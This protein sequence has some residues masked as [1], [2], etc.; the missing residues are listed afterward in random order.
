MEI[1]ADADELT[2]LSEEG[3]FYRY[4]FDK[5]ISHKSGI[6]LDRYGWPEETQ[7]YLDPRT[8]TNRAWAMGKRNLHVLYYEDPF[9]NQHHNGTMEI[10][11]TYVL[12]EDGQEICYGDTGLPSDF[13]RN[14]LGPER[15]AFKA[16][17]LSASASTI[18]V[19][20]D[21]GEMYTRIAD[22]DIIGCD[23]MFFKYTYIPYT[24][25]LPGTDYFSNLT[26]WGLPA[27]DWRAQPSI[28][29]K[30][31]A[32]LTRHITILQNGQGNSARELRVAGLNENGETGYWTKAI[33]AEDWEF[34]AVSLVF[35]ADAVLQKAG[36]FL[37]GERGHSSDRS[38]TGYWWN[39]DEK[40]ADVKYDIPNF[41]ILEG[42]CDLRISL[43]EETC[44]LKLHPVE[45]WTYL[46]RDYL[47]GRS[48]PPKMFFG[49]LDIPERAFD[50][51]SERFAAL[52]REK[53]EKHDKA[54]FYYII[55]ASEHYFFMRENNN[56]DKTLLLTDGSVTDYFPE[57]RRTW[58]IENYEELRR[59]ASSE[60]IFT[61]HSMLT[62]E[63]YGKLL[64]KIELNKAF[65]A[66]LY[67]RIQEMNKHKF[68]AFTFNATYL[69]LDYFTRITFL[70]L[71]DVPKIYTITRFGERIVLTNGIN[72]DIIA[73]TRIMLCERIID[74]VKLRISCYTDL[75]KQL[76]QG[77][78]SAAFPPWF[79][80]TS[81]GYWN[82]AGIPQKISGIFYGP[83]KEGGQ[84]P[85]VISFQTA[86]A[87]QGLL[88]WN[89][90]IGENE[91]PVFFIDPRKSI[92]TIY[93]RKGKTPAQ[94]TLRLRCTL[95]ANT[96]ILKS[97][98]GKDVLER[99]L[100]PF[101]GDMRD[102]MDVLI[103]FDGET[104]EI[105]ESPSL[106]FNKVV[107]RGN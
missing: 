14:Y 16:V 33:F 11:T 51:L 36:G 54:L 79:A 38:L 5:S 42:S 71:I 22:F 21:A 29:L 67:A 66:A 32:A 18:F 93:S 40:E 106:H 68:T 97:G 77:A 98:T 90:T 49:T 57:F 10:A 58:Q 20:N 86:E 4:C 7:L 64:R 26:E 27:E 105:Q 99:S 15:G 35:S 30:G 70:N 63:D 102:G 65:L 28:S 100:L 72:T 92:S 96:D 101:I 47:P 91:S 83:E 44:I 19:I 39:G 59:Y 3:G 13:S 81:S 78:G 17:S 50:G 46:K 69:P 23:P 52:L 75:A 89:F 82:C 41:S 1:S 37:P 62:R 107:F 87:E 25:N 95:Y 85:A 24:S 61:D 34:K 53:F 84:I 45:M 12:L 60:L 2:A 103:I 48:G 80:E 104:F 55:T 88:G 43:R 74:I 94:R 8:V 6:W 56:Q 73:N 31:K 9:G 76:E